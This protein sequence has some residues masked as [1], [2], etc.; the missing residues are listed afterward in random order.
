MLIGMFNPPNSLGWT[1][2]AYGIYKTY[3][4]L[5]ANSDITYSVVSSIDQCMSNCR[6]T[7]GCTYVVF[8]NVADDMR[9]YFI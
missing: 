8:N 7:A 6:N 3:T 4:E 1:P 2:N 9:W 5:P